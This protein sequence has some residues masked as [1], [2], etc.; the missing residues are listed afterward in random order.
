[1]PTNVEEIKTTQLSTDLSGRASA[2]VNT[3][4][5]F[6]VI[7]NKAPIDFAPII[8]QSIE[9]MK[10]FT[11]AAAATGS[12]LIETRVDT[13]ITFV[14]RKGGVF[15]EAGV[16]YK[17]NQSYNVTVNSFSLSGTYAQIACGTA[18]ENELSLFATSTATLLRERAEIQGCEDLLA[19]TPDRTQ[20]LASFEN[21]L[22]NEK[23]V[24]ADRK[25]AAAVTSNASVTAIASASLTA[26][27]LAQGPITASMNAM[28][29][30]IGGL[31]T[32]PGEGHVFMMNNSVFSRLLRESDTTG[33]LINSP[34]F[35]R[36]QFQPDYP[37]GRR[38]SVGLVGYFAGYPVYLT[39]GILSTYTVNGSQ[40]IT[41]QTGGTNS[42]VLFGLPYTLGLYRGVAEYDTITVFNAQNDRQSYYEGE[43]TVGA[44]TYMTAVL[45]APAAWNYRAVA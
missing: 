23:L 5:K 45:K 38:P 24:L 6:Q 34:M 25:A 15:I 3:I 43:V 19:R 29:G 7:N 10:S 13:P 33:N 37:N 22:E 41:A 21:A 42:A 2:W 8:G 40:A 26:L 1:M 32:E 31:Y 35:S 30:N 28:I 11:G 17:T 9:N 27:E 14:G 36:G 39:N 12:G 4:N 20:L 18:T 16:D 44:S